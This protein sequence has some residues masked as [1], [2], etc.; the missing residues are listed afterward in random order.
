M[1]ILLEADL[2]EKRTLYWQ[3]AEGAAIRQG[4][5]KL[6][7]IKSGPWELYDL[8]DDPTEMKDL[9]KVHPE[10]VATLSDQWQV[11]R[12]QERG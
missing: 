7:R 5:W 12:G 8:A 4:H 1:P 2:P 6:V 9:A 10:K 3:H 11:W